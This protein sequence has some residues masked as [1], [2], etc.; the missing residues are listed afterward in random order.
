[1]QPVWERIGEAHKYL[2]KFRGKTI[3]VKYGGDV[4]RDISTIAHDIAFLQKN[5]VR[6]AVVHGGGPQIDE[7]M[8]MAGLEPVKV[9][10]HRVTDELTMNIV[11]SQSRKM[12]D[13]M[14]SLLRKHGVM[15]V[16]L[17]RKEGVVRVKQK[18]PELGLVGAVSAIRAEPLRQLLAEGRVPV[19]SPIGVDAKGLPHNT[20]AD[21]VASN[22]AVALGAARLI[23]LTNVTGVKSKEGSLIPTLSVSE[24]KGHIAD[25]TIHSGMIP[26]VEALIGA[27]EGGVEKAHM[28]DGTKPNALLNE[29]LTDR[30]VG[31]E[32]VLRK[33]R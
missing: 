6:V 17:G 22:L 14:V 2:E 30:G 32:I 15:A 19:T 3:V 20:N 7:A 16:G 13:E 4:G 24:A 25:G 26:K 9:K 23:V 18:D 10:G 12:R 21:E 28:I 5:G 33:K 27:V 8:A 1:M 11:R 29:L 31:T